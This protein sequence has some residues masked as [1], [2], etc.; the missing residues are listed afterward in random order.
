MSRSA[1]SLSAGSL[2][3]LQLRENFI[4]LFFHLNAQIVDKEKRLVTKT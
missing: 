4:R 2:V 1:E 3:T